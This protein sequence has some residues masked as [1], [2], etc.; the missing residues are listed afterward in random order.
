MTWAK[1]N[2]VARYNMANSGVLACN[3]SDLQIEKSDIEPNGG[4]PDGYMPLKQLIANEYSAACDNI[5]ITQGASMANHLVMAA[6]L[7]RGDEVL[8]ESPAYGPLLDVAEYL[9][10]KIKRFSRSFDNKYQPDPNEIQNLLSDKVKLIVLT[11]PHNPSGV[12]IEPDRLLK[13]Q[14]IAEKHGTYIL[15]DQVFRDILKEKAFPSSHLL[16]DNVIA[17]SSLAKSYGLAGLRTG[18]ILSNKVIAQKICR[19]IDLFGVEQA[20]PGDLLAC[21]A[22][23]IIQ[24]LQERSNKI[25]ENNNQ[26]VK[27]FVKSNEDFIECII[28]ERS[29]ILFPRLKKSKDAEQL[30][31]MLR[32]AETS[33]VPGRFFEQP[34]HFRIGFGGKSDDVK[35]GLSRLETALKEI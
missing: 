13:I 26:L 23:K 14:E 32:K 15:I 33:I 16:G 29:I 27:N 25:V 17:T 10:A 22:F 2:A 3:A 21:K 30:H 1:Y 35:E 28:P 6:L 20:I 4:N 18:W 8:I 9:G 7:N 5:N 12:V 11:N 34:A 31:S 24:T 19:L